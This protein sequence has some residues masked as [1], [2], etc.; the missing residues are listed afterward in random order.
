MNDTLI[1]RNNSDNIFYGNNEYTL[2]LDNITALPDFIDI[3]KKKIIEFYGDYWHCNPLKYNSTFFNK[4]KEL[5]A[6]QI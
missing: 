5:T 6:K 1:K 4:H 2:V 3:E